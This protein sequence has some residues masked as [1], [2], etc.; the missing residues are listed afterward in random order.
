M[1]DQHDQLNCNQ[2]CIES[3]NLEHE[4]LQCQ[5]ICAKCSETSYAQNLY[6]SLCNMQWRPLD[7][8][9]IL[10]DHL[11]SVSWRGA[12]RI[13]ADIRNQAVSQADGVNQTEDYMNWYCSG[14]TGEFETKHNKITSGYVAEGVVTDQ[15]RQDLLKL[16]WVPV[17]HED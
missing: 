2:P 4:L 16:G 10:K 13:V 6:S 7:V 11:W 5:W 8:V 3:R 12:G 15:I 1:I 9:S 17:P 14:L